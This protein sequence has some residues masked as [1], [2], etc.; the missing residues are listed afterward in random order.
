[1]IE[2]CERRPWRPAE[3]L[4]LIGPGGAGKSSV[5]SELALL[6]KRNLVDLDAEFRRRKGDISAFLASEGYQEYKTQNSIMA[7]DIV[8]E[9]ASPTVI[10]A[11]SGFLTPDNPEPALKANRS[12][13]RACYSVCLLPSRDFA[14][15][16]RV[17]VERQLTRPF[18]RDRASE[19][20]VIRRR[21]LVY[22][23]LGDLAVFSTASATE[24]AAAVADHFT[25]AG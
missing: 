9:A 20:A 6:L 21:Y 22:A 14:R 8:A 12:L 15:S 5:G 25:K 18:A 19:E 24:T 11:S 23:E 4:I 10:V 2:I 17:I 3:I 1:M 16:V 13:T 7:A